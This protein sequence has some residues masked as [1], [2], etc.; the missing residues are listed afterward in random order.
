MDLFPSRKER[1]VR[2]F[3]VTK[4]KKKKFEMTKERGNCDKMLMTPIRR[5][6]ENIKTASGVRATYDGVCARG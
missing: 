4:K 5:E 1:D 2:K 3:L 6:R